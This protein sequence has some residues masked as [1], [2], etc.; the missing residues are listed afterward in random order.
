MKIEAWMTRD[1]E[2][3]MKKIVIGWTFMVGAVLAILNAIVRWTPLVVAWS[4]E[5]G[6]EIALA[7]Q[8]AWNSFM[9]FQKTDPAAAGLV[10]LIA[11][12]VFAVIGYLL[13]REKSARGREEA[14]GWEDPRESATAG[15]TA[16]S[17][18]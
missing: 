15:A 3:T 5:T 4:V 8:S 13:I 12:A 14:R 6:E 17:F 18:R 1:E 2:T 10:S 16:E 9:V 7:W 11:G